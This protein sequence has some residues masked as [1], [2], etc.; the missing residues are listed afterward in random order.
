MEPGPSGAWKRRRG[1]ARGRKG[2][3]CGIDDPNPVD[4]EGAAAGDADRK[5]HE[6]GGTGARGPAL[7]HN[8]LPVS[9]GISASRPCGCMTASENP[10]GE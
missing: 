1:R 5:S 10:G 6:G 8:R 4:S 9:P 3:V 7:R 2:S